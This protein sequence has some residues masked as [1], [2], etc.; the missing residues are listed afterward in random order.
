MRPKAPVLMRCGG[1]ALELSTSAGVFSKGG[2]D[3]GTQILLETFFDKH[4]V[5]SGQRLCDLGCGWGAVGCFLSKRYPDAQI[6][7]CDINEQAVQL[8]RL[9]WQHN[10]LSN[11]HGWCGDGLSAVRPK[12]F[13]TILCNPPVR[14]GNRV[15]EKLFFDAQRSLQ[16]DGEL[17]VVLRTQQGAKSWH[18]RLKEQFG[19]CD[20][21]VIEKGY[22]VLRSRQTT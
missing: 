17:W 10:D 6:S 16:R 5:L 22:R 20:T 14:A 1:I 15:I 19:N 8:A 11:M 2:L 21:V 12:Y 4:K 9:N 18:K 7:L 3:E 13:H